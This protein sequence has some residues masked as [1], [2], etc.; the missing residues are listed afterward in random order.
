MGLVQIV[1][2]RRKYPGVWHPE[3]MPK[4]W[5]NCKQMKTQ[6]PPNAHFWRKKANILPEE[7][8][9]PS[10]RGGLLPPQPHCS[11][12]TTRP[13]CRENSSSSRTVTAQSF[14]NIVVASLM[15]GHLYPPLLGA[16]GVTHRL[17]QETP[18]PRAVAGDPKY[19]E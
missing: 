8:H 16:W 6:L 9:E 18:V 13:H 7:P 14:D 3:Q 19:L 17:V 12:T 4:H 2:V 10:R 1:M 15:L 5:M 11:L